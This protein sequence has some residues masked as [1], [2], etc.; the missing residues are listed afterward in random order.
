MGEKILRQL[1]K[2]ELREVSRVACRISE[3]ATELAPGERPNPTSLP[4]T[5][6]FETHAKWCKKHVRGDM[7]LL[8]NL[9]AA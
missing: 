9:T 8:D 3:L 4:P 6:S 1:W 7:K 5:Y 2:K